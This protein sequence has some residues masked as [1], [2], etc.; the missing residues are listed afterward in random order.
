[1]ERRI[2]AD[3]EGRIRSGALG[4]GDRLPTEQALMAQYGCARM[5]VSKAIGAL[6]LAGLVVRNRRAGTR[7]AHPR[8]QTALLQIPDIAEE[9]ARRGETYAFRL[10]GRRVRPA[11][12]EDPREAALGARGRLLDLRGLHVAGGAPFALE[13]RV[14]DLDAVAEAET[15]D[16]TTQAPGSWLLRHAPWT[17]ARHRICAT[18]ASPSEAK[19]LEVPTGYAC[20][21]V[22]RWTFKLGQGVTFVRQLFPHDRYDLAADFQNQAAAQT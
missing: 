12:V 6:A 7:V 18:A 19:V 16:F 5:T 14:I 10:L 1:M 9:I 22:E 2:R 15:A 20:L 8:V 3:L 21:Q 11:D 4:P 13:E 17:E